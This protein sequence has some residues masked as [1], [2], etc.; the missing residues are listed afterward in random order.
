MRKANI[1]FL[2]VVL[3]IGVTFILAMRPPEGSPYHPFVGTWE[4]EH[5][6]SSSLQ[7][8]VLTPSRRVIVNGTVRGEFAFSPAVI[9]INT[10]NQVLNQSIE[11]R[12]NRMYIYRN[13]T[14]VSTYERINHCWPPSP[15]ICT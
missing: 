11:V 10:G 6:E 8:I 15:S 2:L 1:L 3:L 12:G 5:G 4:L 7:R 14:L 9:T 13:G